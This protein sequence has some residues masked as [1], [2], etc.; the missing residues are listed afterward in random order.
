MLPEIAV[1]ILDGIS[2]RVIWTACHHGGEVE[3]INCLTGSPIDQE[4]H[5]EH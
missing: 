5:V 3:Y 2:V 4:T 1:I